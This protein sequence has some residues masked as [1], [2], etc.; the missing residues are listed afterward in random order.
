MC[1]NYIAGSD[2]RSPTCT[3]RD[4]AVFS[5]EIDLVY[6]RRARAKWTPFVRLDHWLDRLDPIHIQRGKKMKSMQRVAP[7]IKSQLCQRCY[8]LAALSLKLR[9]SSRCSLAAVRLASGRQRQH[10]SQFRVQMPMELSRVIEQSVSHYLQAPL[11]LA[12]RF[13]AS[14]LPSAWIVAGATQFDRS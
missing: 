1:S 11:Y 9:F 3:G 14:I 6:N 5:G 8:A 10:W 4:R 13:A 12:H 2:P 7:W